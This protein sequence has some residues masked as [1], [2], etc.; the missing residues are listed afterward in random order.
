MA[1]SFLDKTGLSHFWTKIKSYVDGKTPKKQS[2]TLSTSAWAS[3]S[4]IVT[5]S[6]VLADETKQMIYIVPAKASESLYVSSGVTCITQGANALTFTCKELP[7]ANL[8]VFVTIQE[9]V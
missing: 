7:S 8:T 3:N 1:N 2:I 6:G 9:I 5:V 4:Q